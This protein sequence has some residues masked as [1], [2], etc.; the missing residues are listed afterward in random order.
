[1]IIVSII[2]IIFSLLVYTSA[3]NNHYHN[4]EMQ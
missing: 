4:K 1:M 2:N 3:I